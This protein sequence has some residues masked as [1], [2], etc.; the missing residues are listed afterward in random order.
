MRVLNIERI[1]KTSWH[2][3][4]FFFSKKKVVGQDKKIENIKPS[5][6]AKNLEKEALFSFTFWTVTVQWQFF[7]AL[8]T[9]TNELTY[10]KH[11]HLIFQ[12]TIQIH[13]STK[14]III[15]ERVARK[16]LPHFWTFTFTR[17]SLSSPPPCSRVF[18]FSRFWRPWNVS[19]FLFFSR[20]IFSGFCDRPNDVTL[21][22]GK[23]TG[24]I[25]SHNWLVGVTFE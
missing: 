12:Y 6:N 16:F 23:I 13:P 19:L 4:T 17:I 9:Y 25:P 20:Y 5:E 2:I 18:S 21:G 3:F 8:L 14:K 10:Y 15:I 1:Y 7:R 11:A 24:N 22:K